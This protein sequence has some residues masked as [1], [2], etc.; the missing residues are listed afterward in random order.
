MQ[1]VEDPKRGHCNKFLINLIIPSFALFFDILK[2][3]PDS[4][5]CA[6]PRWL[7]AS[8]SAS[9]VSVNVSQPSIAGSL[10]S[11]IDHRV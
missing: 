4:L 5:G 11:G 6:R 9:A 8:D 7:A 1:H 10:G 3:T 2:P